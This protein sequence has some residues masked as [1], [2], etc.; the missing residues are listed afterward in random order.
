MN[1]G[2]VIDGS[3]E[4]GLKVGGGVVG[5]G[6]EVDDGVE[7]EEVGEGYVANVEIETGE[8]FACAAEVAAFKPAGVKSEDFVSPMVQDRGEHGADVAAMSG[9]ED[10]HPWRSF[11]SIRRLVREAATLGGIGRPGAIA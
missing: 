9:D 10:A 4:I 6:G 11:L 2:V 8:L 5:K 3:G 1:G 7:G